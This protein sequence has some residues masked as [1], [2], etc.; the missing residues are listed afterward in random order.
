M[1]NRTFLRRI[2]N[3]AA[4]LST[5]IAVVVGFSLLALGSGQLNTYLRHY[6]QR[7]LANDLSVPVEI[8]DLHGNP[9]KGFRMERVRIGTKEEPLLTAR[10]VEASYRLTS[11][12][13]GSVN[14]E[15]LVLA[16]PTVLLPHRSIAADSAASRL[17]GSD[18][19]WWKAGPEWDIR[20][21]QAEVVDGKMRAGAG[22][23]LDSLNMVLGLRAG[24]A[25]Y[26]LEFRRFRS[27]VFDPPLKIRDLTGLTLLADGRLALDGFQIHTPRSS[28]RIDGTMKGLSSPEYDIVLHA[29]SLAFDEV[30]RLFPG[31]YPEGSLAAGGRVWGDPSGVNLDLK[32][33]DGS[34]AATLSGLVDFSQE[35]VSYDLH[36]NATGVDLARVRPELDLDVRFDVAI[37]LKGRGLDRQTADA[38]LLGEFS[39]SRLFG[40]SVD[41][42]SLRASLA[43]GRFLMDL[44]VEG[45][46][47]GLA[48]TL[49]AAGRTTAPSYLLRTRMDHLDLTRISP[50]LPGIT[51]VTGDIRL[52]LSGDGVWRGEASIDLLKVGGLPPAR[53]LALRGSYRHGIVDIDSVGV[54]LPDPYGV[55]RGHG[56]L[57]LG[58]LRRPDGEKPTYRAGLR[59]DSLAMETLLGRPGLLEGVT[60]QIGVTGEGF[61]PDSVQTTADVMLVASRF[62]GGRLDSARAS[63]VQQGRRT[64]VNRL[65]LAG[66]RAH[67]D[68]R[69]WIVP[70]DSMEIRANGRVFEIEALESIVGR[71]LSGTPASLTARIGGTWEQPVVRAILAAD[72]VNYMDVPIHGVRI[73]M[74]GSHLPEG[75]YS[76]RADSLVWG[77]RSFRAPSLDMS[78]NG[79]SVSF[80]LGSRPDDIDHLHLRARAAR[81]GEGYNLELDSLTV[82]V[83]GVSLSN[84]GPSRATYRP[85]EGA[86]VERFRL[87]GD[88]GTIQAHGHSGKSDGVV[89][90]L[91]GLDLKTWST[92]LGMA[93]D[94]SG[95]LGGRISLSGTPDD[96]SVKSELDIRNG[97]VVGVRFQALSGSLGYVDHHA[98]IDLRLV[99]STGREAS[100]RGRFPLNLSPGKSKTWFPDGPVD[101]SVEADDIDLSLLPDVVSGIRDAEGIL[102]ADVNVTGTT[103]RF[104][105]D[106]WVRIRDGKSRIVPL[107]TTIK[108]VEADLRLDGNRVVLERLEAGRENQRVAL[109]GEMTLDRFNLE[110]YDLTLKAN[111]F[112]AIDLSE[113]KATLNADLQLKGDSRAGRMKGRVALSRAVL[114]LSDFIEYPTDVA[115]MASPFYRNLTCDIRLSAS[116]NVWIRDRELNV[117][118]SGDLDLVKDR[119]GLRVYGSLDSRHGRYEFQN[120]SFAI[121]R[122][123]INFRGS[124]E[125]NP[126]LYIIATRRVRVS[127]ENVLISVV[128]GGTFLNPQIS[129]ESDLPDHK[130]IDDDI[131]SYLLLGMSPDEMSELMAGEGGG[132]GNGLEGRAAVLV[133]GLAANRLK[134][135][136]GQR[137]NLDVVEIDMGMGNTAT[138]VRAGKYFG[139]Q[140]FVSYAQDVSEARGK[141]V[142][143]EYELLPNVTLEAQQREGNERERDRSSLGIF[144]KKQW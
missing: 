120:R 65:I 11:L 105:H 53:G 51:D 9:L 82:E 76:A 50:E 99:Q 26:E 101:V 32:F 87:V 139:S 12:L 7:R 1:P 22:G 102:T 61:H 112:E 23:R 121:D 39:K 116:R 133:M 58:R 42:A 94:L 72:S 47:G 97:D 27:L 95:T 115:W 80:V 84:D 96:P 40:V 88:A 98:S 83:G 68:A 59:V 93:G 44:R 5:V 52:R 75:S 90:S 71:G 33:N 38:A 124:T 135:T 113:L 100:G 79:D 132:G 45:D 25:G 54:R 24:P 37:D 6:A 29:D 142:V 126:D 119:K 36:A 17:P 15:R 103:R 137:L 117:E 60:L 18:P 69:G 62:L 85:D 134:Q 19:A 104:R 125:I 140:F 70:G 2:V 130:R 31:T 108:R 66:P 48:A 10:A 20:I 3:I 73:G 138:R 56:R 55:V 63:V 13:S 107:N 4:L 35:V 49:E 77:G 28:L 106:G 111:E 143:V 81:A 30:R 34:T 91:K 8:G 144:W 136:I 86:Y 141:E 92:I 41:T 89:V 123:E 57:D 127:G 46:A 109:N 74:T 64:I 128:V 67:V 118:I 14:V 78:L 129:L 16:S 21:R 131:L 114:K 110:S 122:G 43:E